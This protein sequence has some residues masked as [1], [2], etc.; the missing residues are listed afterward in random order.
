MSDFVSTV[1]FLGVCYHGGFSYMFNIGTKKKKKVVIL[2]GGFG[3]MYTA[4]TLNK[5]M[6]TPFVS[7]LDLT[8]ID[9]KDDF[10]FQPFLIESLSGE[11]TEKDITIKYKNYEELKG[12]K[13]IKSEVKTV[14]LFER[15]V[16]TDQDIIYYDLLISALGSKVRLPKSMEEKTNVF[17]FKDPLDVE[18]LKHQIS[19]QFKRYKNLSERLDPQAPE[20][21]DEL[22]S[23]LTFLVVGA[24]PTGVELSAKLSD[25]LKD[26]CKKENI[27]TKRLKVILID[28][29]DKILASFDK[30]VSDS[31]QKKLKE[32]NIEILLGTTLHKIEDNYVTLLGKDK[33][34]IPCGN[35]IWTGGT[36][37]NPVIADF[38]LDTSAEGKIL[39]D[40]YLQSLHSLGVFAI[41]DNAQIEKNKM[42]ELLPNTAQVAIQQ[43]IICAFNIVAHSLLLPKIPFNYIE[44]GNVLSLGLDSSSVNVL[45]VQ[46]GGKQAKWFR[47]ILYAVG[48][49]GLKSSLKMSQKMIERANKDK[50]SPL[51][52]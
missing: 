23:L 40:E 13:F 1:L 14:N 22:K 52:F 27:D 19:Y 41:G 35:V 39:V 26:K 50:V 2:G 46:L 48:Y 4:L 16:E 6:S 7:N 10:V 34:N 9:K 21:E 24:G 20:N 8:L 12:V 42:P 38:G 30:K 37:S 49:P 51:P 45:G 33:V 29:N 15:S 17:L 11:L 5:L 31:A 28:I 44:F 25:I 32:K 3:G 18:K 43:A 36:D 47:N